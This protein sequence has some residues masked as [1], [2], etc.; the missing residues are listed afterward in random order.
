MFKGSTPRNEKL[1]VREIDYQFALGEVQTI[2]PDKTGGNFYSEKTIALEE[3]EI[4]K[5]VVNEIELEFE[6]SMK[7]NEEE[8][9]KQIAEKEEEYRSRLKEMEEKQQA[10]KERLKQELE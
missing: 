6:A 2:N 3:E 5:R 4:R 1:K 8:T 9:K 10:E 7:L